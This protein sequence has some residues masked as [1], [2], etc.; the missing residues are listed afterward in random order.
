[1]SGRLWL[2]LVAMAVLVPFYPQSRGFEAMASTPPRA[3]S[4]SPLFGTG[5]E[6]YISPNTGPVGTKIAV[7]G[8]GYHP[9][10][11]VV[12]EV[13]APM[14]DSAG[15]AIKPCGPGQVAVDPTGRL[16]TT[17]TIPVGMRLAKGALYMPLV[18][19][20]YNYGATSEATTYKASS[21]FLL[22]SY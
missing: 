13:L 10:T 2:V 22:T 7:I 11:C 17:M 18:I 1:M 20:T 9:H 14:T 4:S 3:T 15:G 21:I 6:L 16:H 5:P 8:L 19:M 12:V